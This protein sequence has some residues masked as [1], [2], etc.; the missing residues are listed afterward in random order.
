[1]NLIEYWKLEPIEIYTRYF[2]IIEQIIKTNSKRE[3]GH[4]EFDIW[5]HEMF[6][7]FTFHLSSIF[8]LENGSIFSI[9]DKTR[10]VYDYSSIFA[11]IRTAFENY[12]TCF[13]IF[14]N[15]Q[16]RDEL[17]F[18]YLNWW[19]DGLNARQIAD[20]SFSPELVEKKEREQTEILN[21]IE[22]MKKQIHIKLYLKNKNY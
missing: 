15:S 17:T 2:K 9:S 4:K 19:N 11:I 1:M 20:V 21:N 6:V 12:L 5:Q 16:D 8:T 18:R 22:R 3:Y 14:Y 10:N 13:Y 7:K